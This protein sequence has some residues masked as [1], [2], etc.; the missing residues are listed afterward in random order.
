VNANVIVTY[1]NN[2]N[3]EFSKTF[4]TNSFGKFTFN[5]DRNYYRAVHVKVSHDA[6]NAIF[7]DYYISRNYKQYKDNNTEHNL[8]LFT[9]RSIYSPGQTVYFKG[10]VTLTQNAQTEVYANNKSVVKLKKVN[11][12]E[13][14]ELQLET[15]DFGSVSGTFILPNDGLT[16]YYTIEMYCGSKG[17]TFFSV[18]EYKRPKFKP[19]F[20]PITETYRVNDSIT[21]HGTAVAFAGSNI[22]DA[23]VVYR[24]SRQVQY[25]NWH[26]WSRPY[27]SA[28]AQEITF[29]E[30][31]T[32]DKG[33]F[34]ITFK[35]LP[36][37]SVSKDN[38]PIFRYEVIAD[39]TDI[40]GETRI[41]STVVNVGYHS[42]T[43]QISAPSVINKSKKEVEIAI[44]SANL[45]GEEVAAQ[46]VLK[47]YK[48][49]AP[50]HILRNRPWHAPDY[51]VISEEKFKR[52]FPHDP[53]NNEHLLTNWK[54]G[55][56]V[57]SAVFDT[58]KEK[59]IN[60]KKLKRW[61]SGKYLIVTK[62]KDKFGQE[63]KG[64]MFTTLF[65]QDDKT[66][67]DNQLFEA[68]LNK[69]SYKAGDMAKL[70][71]G[72][73]AKNINITVEIEKEG[74]VIS[75]QIVEL[76]N[77]K[78]TI[79]IPVLEN[80]LGGFEVHTSF[81]A[82][83]SYI[84][85]SFKVNVPYPKTDLEIETTTF[86]DKLQPGQDETWSF[87][88]KGP[89]GDKVSAELLASMY[90]ASL[91]EFREHYWIFNPINNPSYYGHI[92]K[93]TG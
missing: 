85:Q 81:A 29:G 80:D 16:G 89:K 92:N 84:A 93:N 19:E 14:S 3:K 79:D 64:E 87:K 42:M 91:D 1:T 59:V 90:D 32:N 11:G 67:A 88:I 35:A 62:S 69:D 13:I 75:T 10:I 52:L 20:K 45:N 43:L 31:K 7:G 61:D 41:A 70:T 39:I 24:V 5:R 28:E 66:V 38:S 12:D 27:Y 49:E 78:Q 37:E 40:N 73:A 71:L 44:N 65:S 72:T 56:E 74:H 63:V 46:G 30:S 17:S 68:A 55:E 9:D 23:K 53:Y 51:Q 48:L 21:V 2:R 18:E 15:N 22:T 57:F 54:K 4:S 58:D 82:F 77:S 50:D 33:E 83:N 8:F 6:D 86:R 76:S 36:D 25:P 34:E 47:I 60:I 26:Y